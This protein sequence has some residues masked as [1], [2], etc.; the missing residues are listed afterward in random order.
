MKPVLSMP[1][2]KKIITFYALLVTAILI[3]LASCT[4]GWKTYIVK[5]G[6]HSATE[7]NP[8]KLNVNKI[9]FEFKADST[10]YYNLPSNSGWSKIRGISHGQHQNNSSARLAY[11]CMDGKFLEVGAYCYVDG[12]SPQQNQSLKGVIDTIQPGRVYHCTISRSKGKY[13]ID[14][15][16]KRWTC[17][18]GKDLNWGYKLNPYIG[19][20]YTLD[21]DWKV[22]IRDY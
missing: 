12:V 14:F 3:T 19:G 21:H 11:R 1:L 2:V 16:N 17:P 10:W 6:H 22:E 7:I 18:A 13:M 4:H 15:E 9:K 20:E 8:I 5:A